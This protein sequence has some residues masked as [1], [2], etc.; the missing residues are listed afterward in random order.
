M[1]SELRRSFAF[2][3]LYRSVFEALPSPE[4]KAAFASALFSFGLDRIPPD[5][6]DNEILRRAWNDV[7]PDLCYSWEQF[8]QGKHGGSVTKERKARKHQK[9]EEQ[10]SSPK[11]QAPAAPPDEPPAPEFL[12]ILKANSSLANIAY[13]PKPLTRPQWDYMVAVYGGPLTTAILQ[14]LDLAIERKGEEAF[15]NEP[16]REGKSVFD[17]IRGSAGRQQAAFDAWLSGTFPKVADMKPYPLTFPQYLELR[18][19]YGRAN[20][21]VKLKQ[22]NE[23]SNLNK[24]VKTFDVLSE[25]IKKSVKQGTGHRFGLPSYDD[26]PTSAKVPEVLGGFDEDFPTKACGSFA[27]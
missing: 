18:S 26:S 3:R 25:W 14:V 27:F 20:V 1:N 5:F 7:L 16:R 22:M 12:K 2:I 10:A 24:R 23:T 8:E 17:V 4:D 11:A 13:S 19:M 9:A 15:W 21:L 6:G